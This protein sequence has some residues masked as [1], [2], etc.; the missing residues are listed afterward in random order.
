MAATDT[1]INPNKIA[2]DVIKCAKAGAAMVHL[3]VRDKKGKLTADLSVLK[4]T[5]ALIRKESDIV[6]EVSTGGVSDLT[7]QERCA[8]LY[9]EEVEAC[10]LNVGSTN[11]GDSVYQNPLP[12]VRYCIEEIKKNNK[13]PEV[14]VFEIGHINTM[15]EL[16]KHFNLE[17]PLYTVV[18]GHPGEAPA[19]PKA[20][21]SMCQYLPEK[22]RW[23][24]THAYRK[25]YE[26]ISAALG[27]GAQTVRIGFEDSNYLDKDH[28]AKF[29]A[30]LVEKIV[31]LLKAMDLEPMNPAEARKFLGVNKGA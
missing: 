9:D 2:D 1:D 15:V 5:L 25:D 20:L 17:D 18:L 6:I 30:P 31:T 11:L 27:L 28:T 22:A 4:E 16:G 21:M 29:N 13:V 8:P 10:S 26:I 7:I 12:D 14:E 24:I 23:G 3:H 19:T